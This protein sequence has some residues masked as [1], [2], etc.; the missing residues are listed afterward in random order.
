[1]SWAMNKLWLLDGVK[2][3]YWDAFVLST[4]EALPAFRKVVFI[5]GRMFPSSV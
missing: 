5:L 1:M 4:R 2:D 3:I